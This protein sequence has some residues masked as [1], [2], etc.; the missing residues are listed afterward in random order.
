MSTRFEFYF[1]LVLPVLIRK[2]ESSQKMEGKR[3]AV[4]MLVDH[5]LI[6]QF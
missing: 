5:K 1:T 4:S 3:I 6:Y 2:K